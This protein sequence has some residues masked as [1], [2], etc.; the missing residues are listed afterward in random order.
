MSNEG[1]CACHLVW[2]LQCPN[3]YMPGTTQKALSRED[4]IPK[5]TVDA[6]VDRKYREADI[7]NAITEAREMLDWDDEQ[8]YDEIVAYA[9]DSISPHEKEYLA[10]QLGIN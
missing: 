8:I 7:D 2:Y 4:I 10:K 5:E 6:L 1:Y 9:G 3:W